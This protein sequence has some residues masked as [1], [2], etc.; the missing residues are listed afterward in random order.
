[1]P[2][3]AARSICWSP[4]RQRYEV[5]DG[6]R[7]DAAAV[8]PEGD[9]WL[10]WLD[11]CASFA[12]QGRSGA[13]CT[14]RK[15]TL[16][17]GGA[18]WYGYRS[19]RGRTVKRYIG[20]TADLRLA[21][22]EEVADAIAALAC[23]TTLSAEEADAAVPRPA[24]VEATAPGSHAAEVDAEE[25]APPRSNPLALTAPDAA[26]TAPDSSGRG[27]AGLESAGLVLA[28]P[29]SAGPIVAVRR[30]AP[31]LTPLLASKL[32]PPRLLGAL[33]ARE[34]LLDRLDEGLS[35]KLTLLSAPAGFGKTTA[36]RQWIA[37]RLEPAGTPVAWV[38][39]DAGDN[40]PARFWRYV[41]TAC[42]S[43]GAEVGQA[44]LAQLGAVLPPPFA[45]PPLEALLTYFLNDVTRQWSG[46]VL[47]LED[48]HVISAPRIHETLTFLVDHLP[49]SLHVVL[50]A[51]NEPP[52]PLL[53]WR[54][55][56]DLQ[57]LHAPD[58][59]F[60]AAETGSFLQQ[61]LPFPL[62]EKAVAQLEA[63]LE[64]WAAG[65][66]LLALSLQGPMTPREL[67]RHLAALSD[68]QAQPHRPI[69]DY[70]ISEVLQA[71]PDALQLFLLR[72][73]MLG[74]LT[75]S[76]CDAVAGRRDSAALLE[77]MERAGLFLESLDDAGQW[78]R[79]HALF[80]DSMRAAA[81]QRLGDAALSALSLQASRWY[82][83]HGL[84]AEAIDA[85]LHAQEH[86]RA[87]D[88]IEQLLARDQFDEVHTLRRWLDQVPREVRHARPHLCLRYAMVL[89]FTQHPDPATPALLARIDD[90]L[91]IA[92]E[93]WQRAGNLIGRGL[94]CAFRAMLNWRDGAATV[95]ARYARQA[96]EWLGDDEGDEPGDEPSHGWRGLVQWRAICLA[97]VAT[98]A[99]YA[100]RCLEA[101]QLF[102]EAQRRCAAAGSRPF[103][104][105]ATLL[106]GA[107]CAA[108]GELHQAEAY[109]RQ[110]I[111]DAEEQEDHEDNVFALLS[112]ADLLYEWNDL[113]GLEQMVE[114]ARALG[115]LPGDPEVREYVVLWQA[116]L[117]HARGRT[118]AALQ[119]IAGLLARLYAL[120]SPRARQIIIG[121]VLWQARLHLAA[122]DLFGA[123]RCLESLDRFE[124]EVAAVQRNMVEVLAARLSLAR[125]DTAGA[126]ARLDGL[127]V[128]AEE[129]QQR[130][131]ALEVQMLM[132][133]AEAASR[134]APEA[135]ER[136]QLVLS[137]AYA[138]GYMRLFL[139][140]GA[141][142]AA[143]LRS[144]LPSLSQP[145]PRAY[146]RAILQAG[147]AVLPTE[148]P[149]ASSPDGM[150]LEPLSAQE[151]RVLGLLA[152][153]RSNPEIARELVVSVNTV[154]DH[155]KSLYRKLNVRNRLE[156]TEAAR[157]LHS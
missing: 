31:A 79:Y 11:G 120:D 83:A 9:A 151:Q 62:P 77:A 56:G 48:Y 40:D 126:L 76:L 148:T 43:V 50:L 2:R 138:E 24:A 16:R 116:L 37:E 22:L 53:R 89:L 91:R 61:A 87:A 131:F 88:L 111:P 74:R 57:E 47:V 46:A 139:D 82:E 58:L 44:A 3:R 63:R 1:M 137:Q 150:L 132:A 144:L 20:R 70:F 107:S 153:G 127:L 95:A 34:R 80:A 29:Q 15:E 110:V 21:R 94:V 130:R 36:V 75:G 54:A 100:G 86:E 109:Y 12:F 102:Q 27:V 135:R 157:R 38:S 141:P 30:V 25:E 68:D 98:E 118:T 32:H 81:R 155:V 6:G 105:I 60:S 134:R 39:L 113:D 96:L 18:Y 10:A 128:A 72:T 143:L 146:A 103:A 156:A 136:L 92:D 123:Q 4:E 26:P 59:R 49:P 33:V 51:R 28:V 101:R 114:R 122:G 140:A 8:L 129:R 117:Q 147:N 97:V 99:L 7:P 17:R 149:A 69:L 93:G 115:D 13:R 121:I 84:L 125:G 14:V 142:L 55:R 106:L 145:A 133:L 64:G 119:Q 65:L 71:Q 23:G 19:L 90:E 124:G 45:S 108:M 67:E 85:A 52:L 112:L 35:R 152:A 154:K 5:W 42:Q 66:R 78:Y 73:S 41:I 104:R